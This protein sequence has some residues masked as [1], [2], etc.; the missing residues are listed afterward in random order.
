MP[1]DCCTA[2]AKS[3]RQLTCSCTGLLPE[4]VAQSLIIAVSWATRLRSIFK[5]NISGCE[6]LKQ[7]IDSPARYYISL[8][9][10]TGMNGGVCCVVAPAEIHSTRWYEFGFCSSKSLLHASET[11]VLIYPSSGSF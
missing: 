5:R 8:E 11:Q 4:S 3:R 6:T 7:T 2:A 10:S 1:D 9:Y